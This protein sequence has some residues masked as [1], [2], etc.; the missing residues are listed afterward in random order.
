MNKKSG[1]ADSPF[2][3]SPTVVSPKTETPSDANER[4]PVRTPERSNTRTVERVNA[5]TSER[6][7]IRHSFQIYEDQLEQMRKLVAMKAMAGEKLQLAD[8][9]KVALD[10]YLNHHKT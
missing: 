9:A 2:F 7:I 8:I 4:T 5:R 3:V 10:D 1:L 6:K